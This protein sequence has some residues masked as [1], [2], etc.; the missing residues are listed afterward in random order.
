MALTFNFLFWQWHF[1][2]QYK[3][4]IWWLIYTMS[5]KRVFGAKTRMVA[6]P[7]TTKRWFCRVFAWRPFASPGKDTTNS[8]R[9]R[10]ACNVAY[11]RVA[12]LKVALRKH[13]KVTI[14]RV[15]VW[16]PFASPGKDTTN[17]RRKG[18][19]WKVS[20][21]R[22]AGRRVAMENTNKLPFGGF[23]R[24]AFSSCLPERGN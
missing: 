13:E 9:K 16:R 19:A 3:A 15:F 7:K 18:D 11:F 24:G 8:S 20:Y 4:F 10:N 14:W 22:V 12:G 2:L 21:F 5:Y 6:T 17:R 1:I 23:S